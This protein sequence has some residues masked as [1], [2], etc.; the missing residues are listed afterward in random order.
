MDPFLN[1]LLLKVAPIIITVTG[2]VKQFSNAHLLPI[3]MYMIFLYKWNFQRHS[4]YPSFR[5]HRKGAPQANFVSFLC[6]P[7]AC[8]NDNGPFLLEWRM[9]NRHSGQYHSTFRFIQHEHELRYPMFEEFKSQDKE[10]TQ[11]KQKLANAIESAYLWKIHPVSTQRVSVSDTHLILDA[12]TSSISYHTLKHF[13]LLHYHE[14][15]ST[16]EEN[17]EELNNT[18]INTHP[19]EEKQDNQEKQEEDDDE[20]EDKKQRIVKVIDQ[21]P[22]NVREGIILLPFSRRE[23]PIVLA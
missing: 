20:W 11:Q 14:T 15:E 2:A 13:G 12:Q 23:P 5:L 6:F 21:H 7:S 1:R 3:W 10:Q 22:T 19:E 8:M 18:I 16:K 4:L 17:K 9:Y